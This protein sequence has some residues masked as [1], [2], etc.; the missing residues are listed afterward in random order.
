MADEVWGWCETA[1]G[2]DRH[3]QNQMV[4]LPDIHSQPIHGNGD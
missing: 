3:G 1:M 4:K 2:P